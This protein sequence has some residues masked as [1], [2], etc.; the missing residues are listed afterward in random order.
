MSD[1]PAVPVAVG[2]VAGIL[3]EGSGVLSPW[4]VVAVAAIALTAVIVRRFR[5]LGFGLLSVVVGWLAA[6][7]HEP[8]GLPRHYDRRTVEVVARATRVTE[9]PDGVQVVLSVDS[10]DHKA[11]A[12]GLRLASEFPGVT[13][14]LTTGAQLRC[15]GYLRSLA[16]GADSGLEENYG[17][18]YRADGVGGLLF[19]NA[20]G[21]EVTRP[22]TGMRAAL[23]RQRFALIDLVY[24]SPLQSDTTDFLVAMLLGRD[25]FLSPDVREDFRQLGI[26]HLLALSGFHVAV[27]AGIIA[28]LLTPLKLTTVGRLRHWLLIAAVWLYVVLTG[29]SPSAVRASILA[30][31][32]MGGHA[33]QRQPSPYNSLAVAAI[34]MLAIDPLTLYSPG[35]Q[36]SFC[37]VLGLIAF[38]ERI[39][40]F[41]RSRRWAHRIAAVVCVPLSAMAG[42]CVV[43][44]A[45]FHT[46]PLMFLVSNVLVCALAPVFIVAGMLTVPLLLAGFQPLLLT[47]FCDWLYSLCHNTVGALSAVSPLQLDNLYLPTSTL[48]LLALSIAVFGVALNCRRRWVGILGAACMLVAVASGSYVRAAELPAGE[49]YIPSGA[50]HTALVCRH[51]SSAAMYSYGN[52]AQAATFYAAAPRRYKRWM[53]SRRCD[54][55][56]LI[57]SVD[58]GCGLARVGNH[59]VCGPHV[60]AII[61]RSCQHVA[62]M[63]DICVIDSRGVDLETISGARPELRLVLSPGL[64]RAAAAAYTTQAAQLNL[65]V[66]NAADS[67]FALRW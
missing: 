60:V 21:Y 32:V 50:G 2:L 58:S 11:V 8:A 5:R 54:R 29:M 43:S 42:T 28:L 67:T 19:C 64:S 55:L 27:F 23:E 61:S 56:P 47:R 10:I 25:E 66:H 37:A 33:L 31:I 17:S 44:I 65:H 16:S 39:N 24:N 1:K 48:I 52:H 53:H 62:P 49:L 20:D 12:A 18:Y 63:A 40:P 14:G 15:R 6:F 30:T 36:L 51:G 46:F 57:D 22:A 7:A 4:F 59:V 45:Y 13:S 35:F 26:A 41:S 34:V 38:G 9:T 3:L